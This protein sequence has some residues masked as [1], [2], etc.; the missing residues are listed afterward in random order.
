MVKFIHLCYVNPGSEY[1]IF[2]CR[3]SDIVLTKAK[4]NIIVL[5]TGLKNYERSSTTNIVISQDGL[6]LK[7]RLWI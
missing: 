3:S 5:V 4:V 1:L 7:E 2:A 6:W